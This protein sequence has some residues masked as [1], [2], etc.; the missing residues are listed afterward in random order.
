MGTST[1]RFLMLVKFYNKKEH[2]DKMLA[3]EL[4][5]GRL[6]AFR[7]TEDQARRDHFEGTILWEGGT[8][9]LRTGEGESLTV[10][11]EDL[12]GPIEMR[13]HLLDTLN[14][15]CMTAFRSNLG[16]WPSWPLVDQVLQ[17]VVES[18]PTCSK[19]GDHAVVIADAK[20]FLM[21]VTRAA[22]RENWQVCSS[23]V[24]YYDSYPLDVAFGDGRWSFAAAFLKPRECRLEREF[25]VAM[26]TGT[27]GDNPVTLDIGDIRD[28]GWH[29]E[30]RE[31]GKLQPRM[32]GI[33]PLCGNDPCE[34]YRM[35]PGEHCKDKS[36]EYHE[37]HDFSCAKCGSFSVTTTAGALLEEHGAAGII[38]LG[39]IPRWIPLVERHVVDRSRVEEAMGRSTS[40]R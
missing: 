27:V 7:D 2:A 16:P 12:A 3:G 10:S 4:R 40:S 6:K 36:S 8:L 14:V 25:R 28:I 20:E 26:N 38:A 15:F 32:R 21:R 18:L 39:L 33:C 23:R 19:F 31:L 13:P 5:A 29:T 9:T 11:P 35:R 24:R 37:L 30:T 17:Q 34:S 1:K 22:E